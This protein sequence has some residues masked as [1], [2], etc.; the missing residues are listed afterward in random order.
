[1]ASVSIESVQRPS[2]PQANVRVTANK[3]VFAFEIAKTIKPIKAITPNQPINGMVEPSIGIDIVWRMIVT[4]PSINSRI[5]VKKYLKAA[6]SVRLPRIESAKSPTK[7][8]K[9][10]FCGTAIS[11]VYL[12]LNIFE[13]ANQTTSTPAKIQPRLIC[14]LLAIIG[15]SVLM[16]EPRLQLGA[17]YHL[18]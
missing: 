8:V 12:P 11:R 7:V 18:N 13:R 16:S 3:A 10:V 17:K 9:A 14:R 6:P 2:A 5:G 4:K 15:A 1:M